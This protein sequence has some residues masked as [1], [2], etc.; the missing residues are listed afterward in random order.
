MI[1]PQLCSRKLGLLFFSVQ[2]HS[3]C[4]PEEVINKTNQKPKNKHE[5]VNYS[6]VFETMKPKKKS[7]NIKKK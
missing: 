7:Q 4:E 2:R 1:C 6:F 3:V 5:D